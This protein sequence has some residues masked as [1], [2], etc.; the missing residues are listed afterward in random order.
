MGRLRGDDDAASTIA[1]LAFLLRAWGVPSSGRLAGHAWPQAERDAALETARLLDDALT[2]VDASAAD[3]REL[4]WR[5]GDA[6]PALI[7]L[8]RAVA[9][10]NPGWARWRRQ[11]RRGSR[12]LTATRPLLTGAE[13]AELTGIEPGPGLGNLVAALTR[14]QVRREVRTRGGA[15]RFIRSKVRSEADLSRHP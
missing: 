6:F 1:R 2:V 7:V 10:E 4:I 12:T 11:W 15:V 3:R 9:P 14:A 13:I 8:A 5:A